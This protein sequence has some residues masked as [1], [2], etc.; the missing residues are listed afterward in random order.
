MTVDGK[1]GD[2]CFCLFLVLFCELLPKV[3]CG[4]G[5]FTLK[6]IATYFIRRRYQEPSDIV[7]PWF[8]K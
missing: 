5:E 1:N 2:A 8:E 3:K 6:A 7:L 4:Q